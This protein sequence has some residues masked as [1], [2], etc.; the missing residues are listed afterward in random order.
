MEEILNREK[1]LESS[2]LLLKDITKTIGNEI[3]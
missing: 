1:S 2:A 3:K